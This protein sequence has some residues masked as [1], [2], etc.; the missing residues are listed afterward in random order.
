MII[1]QGNSKEAL[2]QRE[3]IISQVYRTWTENNP[4][5]R[6]YNR[7]LKNNINI[8]FL[9][10]TETIRHAAKTYESTLAMLQLDTILRN[11]VKYGKPKPPKKG[12]KNQAAFSQMREMR[13]DLAGVGTVKMM[14]GI[15][16]TGEIIQYCI[17]AIQK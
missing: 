5:K 6:V 15:K 4:T 10:I 11:A 3:E 2:K 1:P 16:R 17:T 9:S 7:S 13:Y 14:V 12:V 8:R